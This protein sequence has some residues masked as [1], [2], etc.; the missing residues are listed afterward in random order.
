METNSL[1][2]GLKILLQKEIEEFQ[3]FSILEKSLQEAI[4]SRNWRPMTEILRKLRISAD[5]VMKIEENREKVYKK[6]REVLDSTPEE[7]FY[8]VC[9][10]FSKEER[11]PLL[12][13]YRKLR[14]AVSEV[15]GLTGCIDVY[16]TSSLSTLD[17][18]FEQFVPAGKHKSYSRKGTMNKPSQP[19]L[20]NHAY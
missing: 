4:L 17:K 15:Q 14:A 12:D 1:L 6:L 19:L 3:R 16:C 9:L 18:L 11:D 13:L 20:V 7:T 8:D 10:R 2:E 5:T